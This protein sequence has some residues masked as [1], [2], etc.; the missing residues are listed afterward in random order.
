[1][2]LS[3]HKSIKLRNPISI[4]FGKVASR[5]DFIKS[6]TGKKFIALVDNWVA[7]G[8][9]LLIAAPDWKQRYDDR[10]LIDFLFVGTRKHHAICGSI[11][12]SCDASSRRF[13]FI[14]ATLVEVDDSMGFLPLSPLAIERHTNYQRALLQLAAKAHDANDALW[15]RRFGLI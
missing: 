13:P 12:P 10:G 7:Q 11:I 14:A 6:A 15:S 9:E 5:G 4:Y 1:M 3:T 2:N 8:M